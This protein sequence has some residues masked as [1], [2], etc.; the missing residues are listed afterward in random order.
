MNTPKEDWEIRQL[1]EWLRNEESANQPEFRQVLERAKATARRV[2]HPL[3][4]RWMAAAI[5][6]LLVLVWIS[7]GELSAPTEPTALQAAELEAWESPTDF[8]LEVE[9]HRLTASLPEI[10][11]GTWT[12]DVAEAESEESEQ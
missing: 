3:D 12:E 2:E 4:W 10:E 7:L 1:F 5:P 8:L 9:A 6:A 11:L